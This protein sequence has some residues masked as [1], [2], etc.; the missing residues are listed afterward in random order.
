MMTGI[1]RRLPLV[2]ALLCPFPA[3]AQSVSIDAGAR[4]QANSGTIDF[5]CARIA[6][7]GQLDIDSAVLSGIGDLV[8]TGAVAMIA[9]SFEVGGDWINHGGFAAGNGSV[10][11]GDHCDAPQATIE[12]NTSFA[13]LDIASARGKLYRLTDGHTQSISNALR[14]NGVSGSHLM[15]RSTQPG[16]QARWALAPGGVQQVGWIDVADQ[17]APAGSQWIALG[18][19]AAFNS[20]NSGNNFR[21]FGTPAVAQSIPAT[22]SL[23]LMLLAGLLAVVGV[24]R[25][26]IR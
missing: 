3:L 12:G 2:V 20:I 9:G 6:N 5:D 11:F 10:L 21:W 16:S 19:P 25:F 17:A 13:T 14:L 7:A 8:N 15:I 26:P 1:C 23:L 22:S 18:T 24:A 4:W